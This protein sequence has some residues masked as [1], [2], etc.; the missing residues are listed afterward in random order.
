[1]AGVHGRGRHWGPRRHGAARVD[2]GGACVVVVVTFFFLN[3]IF[4]LFNIQNDVVVRGL[5]ELIGLID[6][7]LVLWRD[8]WREGVCVCVWGVCNDMGVVAWVG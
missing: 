5:I 6:V 2:G 3:I 1:M 7:S 8:G 4:F